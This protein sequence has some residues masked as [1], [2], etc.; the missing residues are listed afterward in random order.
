MPWKKVKFCNSAV[1]ADNSRRQT[2]KLEGVP[3]GPVPAAVEQERNRSSKMLAVV[4]C[5]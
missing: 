4:L 1:S 2:R 3:S 5:E